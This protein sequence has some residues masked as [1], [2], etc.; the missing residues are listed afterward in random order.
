M[1][2]IIYIILF[3]GLLF[4][5]KIIVF[6]VLGLIFSTLRTAFFISI[7]TILLAIL[8]VTLLFR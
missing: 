1:D 2:N 6:P 7:I 5:L 3:L 8:G 4:L